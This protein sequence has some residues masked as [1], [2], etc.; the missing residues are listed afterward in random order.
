MRIFGC[1]GSVHLLGS[2]FQMFD[3][4]LEF[5]SEVDHKVRFWKQREVC[6]AK[7]VL[8]ST[9]TCFEGTLAYESLI[10][11]DAKSGECHD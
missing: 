6:A 8:D 2:V 10:N 1:S 11:A 5:R 4:L 3:P 9:P 7:R